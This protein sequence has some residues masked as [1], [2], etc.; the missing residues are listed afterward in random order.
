MITVACKRISDVPNAKI[1]IDNASSMGGP[2]APITFYLLGQ[3][4]DKLEELKM[5]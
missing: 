2:G 3:E 5:K 4:L 1:N